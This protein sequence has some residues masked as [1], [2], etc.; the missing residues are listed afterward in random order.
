[1]SDVKRPDYSDRSPEGLAK[2]FRHFARMEAPQLDSPLYEAFCCEVAEDPELLAIASRAPVGQTP[3]NMLF[4]AVQ[5]LL[6]NGLDHPLAARYPAL[7]GCQPPSVRRARKEVFPIFRDLCLGHRC[8]IESLISSRRVQTNVV[9]RC[10]CLVPA[11]AT[12]A[13]ALLNRPLALIEIGSSAGLNLHWDRFRYLFRLPSGE[14]PAAWGP[15]DSPVMVET[16][17][18]GEVSMPVLPPTI[19]VAWRT[20]IDIVPIDL[21]D[22]ESVTW[23]RALIW[24][25]HTERHARLEAAIE[26]ARSHAE[27]VREGDAVETL[28]AILGEAPEEAALLVFATFALYQMP[29]D[30]LRMLLQSMQRHSLARA[31]DFLSMEGTG[32]GYAELRWTRYRH[33]ERATDDLARCNPHGRWLEW[34]AAPTSI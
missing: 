28:P 11:F 18:R 24:P 20:G 21:H 10:S 25:E 2:I 1:M 27:C 8:E 32:P 6:L 7:S 23:L 30:R 4:A 34:L 15:P 12:V 9:Q 17:L 14:E 13:A 5:F 31:V 29:R 33:G 16:E 26:L 3:V 19:P 22:R